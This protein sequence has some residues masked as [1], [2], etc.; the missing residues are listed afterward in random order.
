MSVSTIAERNH[1]RTELNRF[2]RADRR[3]MRARVRSCRRVRS[4]RQRDPCGRRSCR[5]PGAP[6]GGSKLSLFQTA[7]SFDSSDRS[8]KICRFGMAIAK[9]TRSSFFPVPIGLASAGAV[10]IVPHFGR[11]KPSGKSSTMT[12]CLRGVSDN[13]AAHPGGDDLGDDHDRE[14]RDQHQRRPGPTEEV[15]CAVSSAMPMP[16]RA[17]EAEHG[18]FAHVDVPAEQRDRQNAGF[19]LRPVALEQDRERPGRAG[20]G[21]RLDRAGLRFLERLAEELA[22]EADRTERRSPACRRARP[23]RRSRRRAAPRPASSPSAT[24]PA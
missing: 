5:R 2:R 23:G 10:Q 15:R 21:Q 14:D 1:G 20:G 13:P 19:D 24:R 22:D 12:R 9:T 17:D 4:Q 11:T 16:P 7:N 8:E 18:R 3:A 6:S